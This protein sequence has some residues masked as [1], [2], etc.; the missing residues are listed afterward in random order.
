VLRRL[1]DLALISVDSITETVSLHRLVQAEFRFYMTE[2][3]RQDNFDAAVVLLLGVFP[4]RGGSRVID[5]D[6]PTAERY[7]PQVLALIRN[8][9]EEQPLRSS[10]NLCNLICDATW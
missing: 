4:S 3:D 1:I 7:I 9:R 8:Y 2:P 5:K 6:W 10:S